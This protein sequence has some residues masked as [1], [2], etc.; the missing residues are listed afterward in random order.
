M[1]LWETKYSSHFQCPHTH[2]EGERR[3]TCGR[4]ATQV[5]HKLNTI[6]SRIVTESYTR[7]GSGNETPANIREFRS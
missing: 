2:R 3:T 6:P 4:I 1:A 5:S 7:Q